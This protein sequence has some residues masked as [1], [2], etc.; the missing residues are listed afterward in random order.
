M[1]FLTSE[2]NILRLKRWTSALLYSKERECVEER[3]MNNHLIES[4][5][6]IQI[7]HYGKIPIGTK[8]EYGLGVSC[9]E[10]ILE[11]N[12]GNCSYDTKKR[13]FISISFDIGTHW[14]ITST[15]KHVKNIFEKINQDVKER[16]DL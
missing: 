9:E 10:D 2:K 6:A 4:L 8:N 5:F 13:F 1:D 3:I 15:R 11:F 7:F 14:A 16:R 12:D